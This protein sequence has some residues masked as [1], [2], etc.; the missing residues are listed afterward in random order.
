[1]AMFVRA[2]NQF[3]SLLKVKTTCLCLKNWKYYKKTIKLCTG[4]SQVFTII[5][6]KLISL[7]LVLN[8][9]RLYN[10]QNNTRRIEDMN[11]IFSW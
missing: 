3:S 10:E 4:K 11:F 7:T 6:R 2:A 8:C 5:D 1:M 9:L